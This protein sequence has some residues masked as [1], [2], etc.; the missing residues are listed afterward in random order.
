MKNKRLIIILAVIVMLLCIPLIAMQFSS[1]LNWTVSDFMIA[2]T[3]LL[4]SGLL[5]EFIMR[6]VKLIKNRIV[7]GVAFFLILFLV[8]IEL[9]VGLFGTILSGQ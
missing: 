8:W 2:G 6:K 3:L 1:N 5:S 4:G 9:S 7:I